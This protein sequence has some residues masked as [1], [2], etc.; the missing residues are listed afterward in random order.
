MT[1][2]AKLLLVLLCY[3]LGIGDIIFSFGKPVTF[4]YFN[5][6]C[7]FAVFPILFWFSLGNRKDGEWG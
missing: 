7:L 1:D 4:S 5:M 2:R 3:I 6:T